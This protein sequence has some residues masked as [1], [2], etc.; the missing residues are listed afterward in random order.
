MEAN[1]TTMAS[2]SSTAAAP[3][4]FVNV[5]LPVSAL[6]DPATAAAVVVVRDLIMKIIYITVG[7]VDRSSCTEMH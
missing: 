5:S 6:N 3:E 2:N 1:F 7:I 4:G